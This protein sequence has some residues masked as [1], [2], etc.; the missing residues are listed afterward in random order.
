VANLFRSNRTNNSDPVAAALRVSASV[1]GTPIPIGCGQVRWAPILIDYAGFTATQTKS[2]GGK[3]GV[4]GSSG[5]GN[6]G[7]YTYSCSGLSL[8]GEGQI[9]QVCTIYNGS[10]VD[11]LVP[12]T[13][14]MLADL[15]AMGIPSSD[16]TQGNGTY[17]TIFH[18]GDYGQTNDSWWQANFPSH[19]L[20]YRGLSYVIWPNLQLG[21]SP[22]FPAFNV[23]VTWAIN[24]D[25]PALGPDA[26]P[27]DWI[28][29][30][31]T[32]QDWGVQGFPSSVIGDFDTARNYWRATG[33]M[34]SLTLA[35]QTSANSHIKAL[36]DALNCDFRQSGAVF[37]IVP[38]GDVSVTGNGY[39]YTP[40]TT[41]VYDLGVDDFLPNQGSLGQ[42]SASGKSF[43][44]FSAANPLDVFN[45]LQI[46]YN[47]RSN[48]YNP[49]TIYATDDASITATS[50][51]R[52]SDVKDNS[53]FSLAS[54][55]SVSAALQLQR[56]QAQMRQWQC[57]VGRQF[58]LLDVLDLVTLTEPSFQLVNQLVRITQIDE[59]SDSTLTLTFEE[60]PLTASAPIY[61]TQASIGAGRFNNAPSGSV[62]APFF[63][64]PPDQLGDGLCL[65][66]GLS[67]SVPANYG[68]CDV[69]LST[70]GENYSFLE[71]WPGATRMGVLTA[72]LPSV[73]EA[74]SGQTIDATN[75]LAV[76]LSE[77]ETQLISVSSVAFDAL[78]TVSVVDSEVLAYKTATLIGASAY[79]LTTLS[80][81]AYTS[82][83][84]AHAIRA[85][86][87]RLDGSAYQWNFTS[88]QVGSTVY[89]K[90]CAFNQFG[91]AAQNLADV[92]PYPYVVKGSAL[93]SP[94]P[95]VTNLT[96]NYVDSFANLNWTEVSDF[97]AVTYEVRVG[98]SWAGALT[99]GTVAHPPFATRGD[100]TFWVAAKS[101]PAPGIL[102]YSE[103]P[104]SI[105]IAGNLLVTNILQSW[106]EVATRWSGALSGDAAIV[107]ELLQS[108]PGNGSYQIPLT[109]V[110]NAG[111]TAACA[112]TVT[113][114]A[115]GSPIGGNI[116][117]AANVLTLADILGSGSTQFIDA[118]PQ[119]Q[120]GTNDPDLYDASNVYI[121]PDVYEG[122][123][124]YGPWQNYAPGAYNGQ[125]FN[126]RILLST[127]DPQTICN[128]SAFSFTVSAPA[129]N[130]HMN[131]YALP[132]GGRMFVFT[133]DGD[134]RPAIFN[135]GPNGSTVPYV[136][137]TIINPQ[138]GDL[139]NVMGLTD[140]HVTLQIT[141]GGVGVARTINAD[142]EGY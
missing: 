21:S 111:R 99:L 89:F 126:F 76:N 3:G 73:A 84:A 39:T 29:A 97:R 69:Y 54:A 120:I 42:G 78:A 109:H 107:G 60:V 100:G 132:A 20:A 43:L 82:S 5:K 62:N 133:P 92:A 11:F 103:T 66:I 83:I 38:Y 79:D 138:A 45:K 33:M 81:G 95:N 140:V 58:V 96:T 49:V 121:L 19:A 93:S 74:P 61:N 52:L 32:N 75:T 115:E 51:V 71:S 15:N 31:L 30:F 130:D 105:E 142:F 135:G 137:V 72:T 50:R 57:T 90:F 98:S 63:F 55:A 77:S 108:T 14:Q 64:E 67:G 106:D 122:N 102:V 46:K 86:F 124:I 113:W 4:V 48:L 139:L 134:T 35:S 25:I 37:D 47:D 6:T 123:A 41:P 27:A 94:L 36:M 70:D 88:Q 68:G 128:L 12:P 26:N 80:R 136:S 17:N 104:V 65:L 44:A 34:I 8:L 13:A 116:L 22:S 56:I 9:T 85:P 91:V 53:F 24:S 101:T 131:N 141:N 127:I 87:M 129:R 125:Y 10:N 28:K 7:Q 119:I 18:V 117:A 40:N 110:I 118:V 23:E 114:A 59:N 16:I 112:V 1:Q 2:S